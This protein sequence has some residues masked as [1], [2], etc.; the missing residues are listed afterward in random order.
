[1]LNRIEEKFKVLKS[2][3]K[4]AMTCF[5]TSGDPNLSTSKKIINSLPDFGADL[6]EIGL[7]FSDPMADGPTIQ[8]S[9]Q[10]AIKS[11]INIEKTLKMIF[12]F[13]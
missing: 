13:V 4:K 6:I 1:M 11:G 10:R 2:K 7:P 8:K 3:K 5:V 9:S 12:I